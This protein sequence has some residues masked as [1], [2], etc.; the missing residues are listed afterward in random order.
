MKKNQAD[1]IIKLAQKG[2]RESFMKIIKPVGK[3]ITNTDSIVSDSKKDL[4]S[5]GGLNLPKTFDF[6]DPI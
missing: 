5:K 4:G 2:V 6:T 3:G 1:S